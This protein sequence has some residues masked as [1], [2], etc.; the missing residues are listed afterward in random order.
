MTLQ[1]SEFNTILR[2]LD[3]VY[4]M[5]YYIRKVRLIDYKNLALYRFITCVNIEHTF[6]CHYYK[7]EL[8]SVG[9]I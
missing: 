6:Y 1:Y 8:R 4:I 9:I 3:S 2:Q 5:L 7:K